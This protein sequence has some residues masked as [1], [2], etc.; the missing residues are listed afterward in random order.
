MKITGHIE[1]V[2]N[3]KTG[4]K[5]DGTSWVKQE[6]VLRLDGGGD[7]PDKL[8]VTAFGERVEAVQSLTP[9]QHVTAFVDCKVSEWN[10]KMYNNI[11]LFK[12]ADEQAT[13]AQAAQSVAAETKKDDELP[14]PF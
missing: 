11:N 13:A 1:R 4:A 9:E 8:L 7:Y 12:F 3:P 10:G 5:A 14:F 2:C 6:F